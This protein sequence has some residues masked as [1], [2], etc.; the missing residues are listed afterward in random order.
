[1]N[2]GI[3]NWHNWSFDA[4]KMKLFTLFHFLTRL[5]TSKHLKLFSTYLVGRNGAMW[6]KFFFSYSK[7]GKR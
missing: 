1:M 3:S 4:T 5:L 7:C 6:K 2:I